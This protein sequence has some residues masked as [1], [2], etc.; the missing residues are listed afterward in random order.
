MNAS[1][2]LTC[3]AQIVTR[4]NGTSLAESPNPIVDVQVHQVQEVWFRALYG[5]TLRGG[6]VQRQITRHNHKLY[7]VEFLI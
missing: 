4:R 3:T 5:K 1:I 6:G 7:E 2:V